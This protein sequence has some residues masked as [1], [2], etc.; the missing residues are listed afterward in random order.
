MEALL[1]CSLSVIAVM[2]VCLSVCRACTY[3]VHYAW[4]SMVRR[5]AINHMAACA[6]QLYLTP[7]QDTKGLAR[8]RSL[9]SKLMLLYLSKVSSCSVLV[10]QG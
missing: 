10:G 1:F 8:Y 5:L 9:T 6:G 3:S 2:Y 7:C 4:Q